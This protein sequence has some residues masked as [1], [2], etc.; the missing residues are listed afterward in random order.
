M[1][2]RRKSTHAADRKAQI[3]VAAGIMFDQ[4][5]SGPQIAEELDVDVRTITRALQRVGLI[6]E[7]KNR[8]GRPRRHADVFDDT[9]A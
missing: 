5:M 7:P 1:T 8:V 3:E 6:P 2:G 9:N 4:G